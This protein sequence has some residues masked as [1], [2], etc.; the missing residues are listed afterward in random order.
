MNIPKFLISNQSISQ[1][2]SSAVSA[3][4]ILGLILLDTFNSDAWS[5]AYASY[6]LLLVFIRS[7]LSEPIIYNDWVSF[8]SG[9]I[10]NAIKI[11]IIT[12]LIISTLFYLVTSNI[13]FI[14]LIIPSVIN[15]VQDFTRYGLISLKLKRELVFSDMFWCISSCLV[16]IPLFLFKFTYR[17]YIFIILWSLLGAVSFLLNLTHLKKNANQV[18]QFNQSSGRFLQFSLLFDKVF[19]RVVSESQY[20]LIN[21]YYQNTVSEYRIANLMMGFSNVL[22]MSQIIIWIEDEKNGKGM[23]KKQVSR[24]VLVINLGLAIVALVLKSPTVAIFI[25]GLSFSA[26][27]DLSITRRIISL[28]LRGREYLQESVNLRILSS[29]LLFVGFTVTL[30][31]LPF[32]WSVGYAATIGSFLSLLSLRLMK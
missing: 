3:Q 11:S 24:A 2:F 30:K 14:F 25:T 9:S 21:V 17:S 1:F 23:N 8:T 15:V 4:L 28:R 26:V 7:M 20:F 10:R 32:P 5:L 29:L 31:I 27:L 22:V 18:V 12:S 16:F 19:P 6:M 13:Y